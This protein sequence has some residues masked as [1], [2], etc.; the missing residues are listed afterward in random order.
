[1]Y[2]YRLWCIIFRREKS[3]LREENSGQSILLECLKG[4]RYRLPLTFFQQQ[5]YSAVSF[6]KFG[7]D[8][9]IFHIDM[10]VQLFRMHVALWT[11]FPRILSFSL[12]R[13]FAGIEYIF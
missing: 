6:D 3:L 8:F 4:E 11:L 10:E 2:D 1:M 13:G 9:H 5:S 12:Y 7:I